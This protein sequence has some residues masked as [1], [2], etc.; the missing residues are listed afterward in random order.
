MQLGDIVCFGPLRIAVDLTIFKK[1]S[2]RERF[3]HSL[4]D[5]TFHPLGGQ[6]PGWHTEPY[7]ECFDRCGISQSTPLEASVLT[8]TP[9]SV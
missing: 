2:I 4:F 5:L 3:P 7:K 6:C 8:S 9:F 1:A